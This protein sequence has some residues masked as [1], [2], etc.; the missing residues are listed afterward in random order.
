MCSC[1]SSC[2]LSVTAVNIS[3]CSQTLLLL[4]ILCLILYRR[5]VVLQESV[6]TGVRS[7]VRSSISAAQQFSVSAHAAAL[8]LQQ[9]QSPLWLLLHSQQQQQ[10]QVQTI[11]AQQ[12]TAVTSKASDLSTSE[13]SSSRVRSAGTTGLSLDELLAR[14]RLQQQQQQI[15]AAVAATATSAAVAAI[16]NSVHSAG[17]VHSAA[18]SVSE[19]SG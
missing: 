10:Q 19:A 17:S 2:P 1:G 6:A 9:Q 13:H 16:S 4:Y 18:A 3:T 15:S 11:T 8:Q 5:S 14:Q 7:T 12:L